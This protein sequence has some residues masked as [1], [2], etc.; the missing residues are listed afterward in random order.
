MSER[1]YKTTNIAIAATLISGCNILED[2]TAVKQAAVEMKDIRPSNNSRNGS[3]RMD[4]MCEFLFT[5]TPEREKITMAYAGKRALVEP[6]EFQNTIRN[7]KQM[8]KE[9]FRNQQD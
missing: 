9:Y 2:G 7:L 4:D 6:C 8:V 5:D 1:T 3:R